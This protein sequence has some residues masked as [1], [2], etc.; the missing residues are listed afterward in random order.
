MRA[1]YEEAGKI[2]DIYTN[3]AVSGSDPA[4]VDTDIATAAEHTEAINVMRRQRDMLALDG[5]T[6]AIASQDQ[7]ANLTPFLQ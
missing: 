3:E 2:D 7:I 1:S 5:Q 6:A 4:F